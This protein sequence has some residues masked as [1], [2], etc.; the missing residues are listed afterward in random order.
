LTVKTFG[1]VHQQTFKRLVGA[2]ALPTAE[3]KR[4]NLQ[5]FKWRLSLID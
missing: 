2:I 5:E 3:I 1:Q 4:L